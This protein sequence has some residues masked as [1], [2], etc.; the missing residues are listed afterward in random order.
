MLE[1]QTIHQPSSILPFEY[2]GGWNTRH[3]RDSNGSPLFGFSN[4]VL[5]WTKW[6][7]ILSKTIGNPNKVA[8]IL[9][10]VT[11]KVLDFEEA[12]HYAYKKATLVV[13]WVRQVKILNQKLCSYFKEEN[14]VGPKS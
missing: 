2:S 4:G 12:L 11:D 6:P 1:I 13:Q 9:Y 7:P 8:A 3:I 14:L 10:Y 5:F